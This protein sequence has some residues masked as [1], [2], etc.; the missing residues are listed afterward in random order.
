MITQPSD[1]TA[2]PVDWLLEA[3]QPWVRAWTLR[4]L[5]GQPA[6]DPD[7]VAARRD[8]LAHPG[9]RAILAELAAWPGEALNRHNDAGH[10]L[11]KLSLLADLVGAEAPIAADPDPAPILERVLASQSPEGPFTVTLRIHERF[12]GDGQ[13]HPGW[14]A[15]DAPTVLAALLDFGLGDD[16]RVRHAL[17]HLLGLVED[18][19]WRCVVAREMGGFRG[20]GRYDDACP[21]ATLIALRAISRV[22][23]LLDSEPAQRGIAALLHLWDIQRERKPYLFGMGTDF[24]KPKYPLV[25]YDL[26]HMV[27]VLSRFPQARRDTRFQAMLG[28]LMLQSD[29]AGRFTARSMYTAWK[30]WDFA[31]KKAPSPTITAVAWRAFQ[32][33]QEAA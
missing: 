21:Y 8:T 25:W 3:G 31:D 18:N 33:A 13:D 10:L 22:P 12:G 5:V 4:D 19:G 23:A 6:D 30:G 26:L 11:H 29:E 27:D 2:M 14:M 9:V 20:P 28:E 7:V 24:R 1:V 17:D 16:P 32:R 15:C